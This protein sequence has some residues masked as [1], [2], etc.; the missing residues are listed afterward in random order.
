MYMKDAWEFNLRSKFKKKIIG[1]EG[2]PLPSQQGVENGFRNYVVALK[3]PVPE[4][5]D[6]LI[7]MEDR[8]TALQTLRSQV[9]R[10]KY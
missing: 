7:Q 3:V 4:P 8:E 10:T 9:P 6:E 1:G 2:E 5:R